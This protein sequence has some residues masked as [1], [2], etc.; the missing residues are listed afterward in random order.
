[1]FDDPLIRVCAFEET[2][3][4][5]FTSCGRAL[6]VA[7]HFEKNLRS[8]AAALD[9]KAACVTGVLPLADAGQVSDS[10]ERKLKR[11]LYKAI[12]EGLLG[13]V[14]QGL[15]DAARTH[16]FPLSTKRERPETGLRTS[17]SSG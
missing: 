8:I 9:V 6:Y 5:L 2:A 12:F 7:Q 16:L 14:P 11:P 3:P 10:Y 13:H 1:M 17:S 4:E 15:K